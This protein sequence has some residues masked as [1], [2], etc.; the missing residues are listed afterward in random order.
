MSYD[1]RDACRTRVGR[2]SIVSVPEPARDRNGRLIS[3]MRFHQESVQGVSRKSAEERTPSRRLHQKRGKA[4]RLEESR[5]FLV[6]I[7]R[8]SDV[9]DYVSLGAAWFPVRTCAIAFSLLRL[10]AGL[11][12]ICYFNYV[13]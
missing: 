9:G 10:Q 3:L 6:R 5:L 8:E 4:T 11:L 1:A 2:S 13:Y 12:E 7:S